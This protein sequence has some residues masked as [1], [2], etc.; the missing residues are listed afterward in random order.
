MWCEDVPQAERKP[1]VQIVCS[2]CDGIGKVDEKFLLRANRGEQFRQLR[3]RNR[4]TLREFAKRFGIDIVRVSD[5]ERGKMVR[6]ETY[7]L[8]V[9]ARKTLEGRPQ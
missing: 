2:L 1:F 5:F 6:W 4:I 7:R 8:L 3:I 9:E